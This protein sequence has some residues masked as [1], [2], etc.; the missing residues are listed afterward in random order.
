MKN[1]DSIYLI[2]RIHER[3]HDY[4]MQELAKNGITDF[5]PSHGDIISVLYTHGDL[6]MTELA[7]RIHRDRSTVTTLVKKMVKEE[8]V[9]TREDDKDRR[10]T[11]VSLTEKGRLLKPVFFKISEE[12]ITKEYNGISEDEQEAFRMLLRKVFDNF[13]H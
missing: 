11:I 4:L 5:Y 9:S 6:Y 8:Y 1:D 10:F 13:E 2:G 7:Q 3:V 12:M